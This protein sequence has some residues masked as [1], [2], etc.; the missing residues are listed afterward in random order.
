VPATH[1]IRY[2]RI[3][4]LAKFTGEATHTYSPI[5]VQG[6]NNALVVSAIRTTDL[7]R[8]RTSESSHC[9][10]TGPRRVIGVESGGVGGHGKRRFGHCWHQ[11][12]RVGAHLG[13]ARH[14][15]FVMMTCAVA[16]VNVPYGL[17]VRDTINGR[18]ERDTSGSIRPRAGNRRAAPA[19]GSATGRADVRRELGERR[20]WAIRVG[21]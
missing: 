15:V 1:S 19:A 3:G 6:T 4:L 7:E 8:R 5:C 13:P 11:W 18:G 21:R 17:P 12:A 20:A 9:P 2:E 10:V 16:R 14:S